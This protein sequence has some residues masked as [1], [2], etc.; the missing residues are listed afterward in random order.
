MIVPVNKYTIVLHRDGY[1]TF[2]EQLQT[3][4]LMDVT[5]TG[6]ECSAE[7]LQTISLIKKHRQAKAR[8]KELHAHAK[9]ADGEPY[10]DGESAFQNY[11]KAT[12]ELDAL[13]VRIEHACKEAADLSVWGNFCPADLRQL[14]KA[15]V[16]FHYFSAHTKDFES[17]VETWREEY[18]VEEIHS[19]KGLTYFVVITEPDEEVAINAQEVNV[20][21]V[22]IE[23]KRAEIAAL[24]KECIQWDEI[25]SRA[26]ASGA[27]IEAHGEELKERLDFSRVHRSGREEI[28][29]SLVV[30]EGWASCED[31]PQMEALL[32]SSPNLIYLKEKPTPEDD[33]PVKLKNNRFTQMFELIGSFYSLPK[34]GSMDLTPYFA[35]FYMIF[36]GFC[37]G[38][39]G[40]GLLFLLS[41]IFLKFKGKNELMWR[42]GSLTI[43]LGAT[44]MVFGLLSGGYFG[45]QFGELKMFKD[46]FGQMPFLT[47]ALTFGV[48]QIFFGM[49]LKAINLTRQFGFRYALATLGWMI[50]LISTLAVALLREA[51]IT[52]FSVNS[53]L[54]LA[55]AGIGVF[56]MLFL[57]SPGKNPLVNFGTGLWNAYNNIVGFIGDCMSY[58]RLFAV[59]LSGSTLAFVFNDLAMEMSPDIPV[60]KQLVML[61]ILLVGH[62][63]NLFMSSIGAFVH[64]MRL[65]FVEFFNN[66]GFKSTQRT[67]TPFK[68]TQKSEI[69]C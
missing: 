38:D 47:L 6:L 28:D 62:G 61:I 58:I 21:T 66:A 7:E 33:T 68:R 1:E 43:W 63:I 36:F 16:E 2:L 49:T 50:V 55:P 8:F 27:L 56:M 20:P 29:G 4:G 22:T 12:G 10:G 11:L 35:P 9:F 37:L 13:H 26:A 19:G 31:S 34:Y 54:Y 45:I 15:G 30:L 5:T 67:F 46:I 69:N 17:S 3:L 24:K 65:T 48:V 57:N 18:V 23:E 51:G 42:I 32:E 25:L 14:A 52:G 41:G 59:G 60:V 44:T 40:Y 64:P 53:P 39:G